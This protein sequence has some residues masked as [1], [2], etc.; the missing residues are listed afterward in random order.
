MHA[1]LACCQGATLL[2]KTAMALMQD[3]QNVELQRQVQQRLVAG[4]IPEAMA[5]IEQ[6]APGTLES[7][8]RIKFQL[9]CQQFV[10]MVREQPSSGHVPHSSI[11]RVHM[12]NAGARLTAHSA[13][14]FCR[15]LFVYVLDLTKEVCF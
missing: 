8:P 15:C 10:E 1:S 2:C 12:P 14:L 11:Y 13:C 7:H 6:A 5:T 3:R 4:Q 9:Q